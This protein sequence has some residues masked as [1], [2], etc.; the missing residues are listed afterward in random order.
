[1]RDRSTKTA[2]WLVSSSVITL[3][4]SPA[5]AEV[6]TVTTTSDADC[7]DNDC[8]L[9]AALDAAEINGDDDTIEIAAGTYT[10]SG[11]AFTYAP[12][13]TEEFALT[14]IGS[15]PTSTFLDGGG[16]TRVLYIDLQAIS[17]ATTLVFEV[18]DL[19]I[20]NGDTSTETAG[21]GLLFVGATNADFTLD[22]C[23]VSDNTL[24]FTGSSAEGGGVYIG[25]GGSVAVTET[26][27]T[28]N[29]I[30]T[31][32]G[33]VGGAL[34]VFGASSTNISGCTFTSNSAETTITGLV[35]GGA[36]N[37]DGVGN[38]TLEDCPFD[39][40]EATGPSTPNAIIQ[41]GGASLSSSAG[42]STAARNV[43]TS[44]SATGQFGIA[45]GL[46]VGGN[47]A[48]VDAN[49]FNDNAATAGGAT[50]AGGCA[51][52]SVNGSATLV[53]NAFSNCTATSVSEDA[54]GGA[55]FLAGTPMTMTNDTITASSVSGTGGG[56]FGVSGGGVAAVSASDASSVTITNA[57]VWDNSATVTSGPNT[58]LGDDIG[59]IDDFDNNNVGAPVEVTS[60]NFTDLASACEDDVSCAEDITITDAFDTDPLF[61]DASNGDVHLQS[62]S[63]M[64]DEGATGAGV[65]TVDFD[66]DLRDASP[67]IGADEFIEA[68][69]GDGTTQGLEE[70]DDGNTDNG[71]CCDSN[72][73][74]EGAGS[75]CGDPSNTTCNLAD[76]CDGAGLCEANLA[77]DGTTCSD[78]DACTTNDTCQSGVCTGGAPPVCNDNIPCTIDTCNSGSGCVFTPMQCFGQ[79]YTI[80][81]TA[82][83]DKI[84]GTNGDDVIITLGGADTVKAKGGNDRI[85][86]GAGNDSLSGEKGNDQ[87][88][89]GNDSDKLNGGPGTDT[90]LNGENTPGC[91]SLTLLAVQMMLGPLGSL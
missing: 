44:N 4:T 61:V 23:D 65:P 47:A 72:C 54:T 3:S 49:R 18:L 5:L 22:N 83:D 81:G 70:C 71:D 74:F 79:N 9:Q 55:L 73:N 13:N 41:G 40:N 59:L 84:T 66:G 17:P 28:N 80:C 57:I 75:A 21:G 51:A 85:C 24:T 19:T 42:T 2:L 14:I 91:E 69:C 76:T 53:N 32:S 20:Q 37:V 36:L 29:S 16:A 6:F 62:T 63:P 15:E 46:A 10:T 45:G 25:T 68:T 52:V 34:S 39:M 7:S 11:S 38:I 27:F 67:D 78:G 89:G 35:D 56:F 86:G 82:G 8:T 87:I 90:C 64:I 31:D 58:P 30:T 43:F 1:M 33:A 50:G 48:I 26:T 77:T 88:D 12:P 60:S